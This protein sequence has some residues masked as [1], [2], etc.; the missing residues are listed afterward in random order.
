MIALGYISPGGTTCPLF[1]AAT[2]FSFLPFDMRVTAITALLVSGAPAGSATVQLKKGS[3]LVG[4]PV[5]LTAPNTPPIVPVQDVLLLGVTPANIDGDARTSFVTTVPA[6][7]NYIKIATAL[8]GEDAANRKASI[9]SCSRTSTFRGSLAFGPFGA[10][11]AGASPANAWP[12]GNPA[13]GEDGKVG[14]GHPAVTAMPVAGTFYAMTLVIPNA[15]FPNGLSLTLR[16]NFLNTALTLTTAGNARLYQPAGEV[17]V[18]A[19]DLVCWT[20][21]DPSNTAPL[22]AAHLMVAFRP[23]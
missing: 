22:G 2:A 12:L 6:D 18:N 20:L 15:D 7:A 14:F 19:G 21:V 23:D 16:R 4:T 10:L 1:L 9:F 5:S 3:T 17:H 11:H 8:H 13:G